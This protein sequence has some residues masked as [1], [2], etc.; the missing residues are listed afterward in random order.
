MRGV[1]I[2][3][4][5]MVTK[6]LVESWTQ[7]F[8]FDIF[9][10]SLNNQKW[11]RK[12]FPWYVVRYLLSN[13]KN[14]GFSGQFLIHDVEVF[15]ITKILIPALTLSFPAFGIHGVLHETH[16]LWGWCQ[17]LRMRAKLLGSRIFY[18]NPSRALIQNLKY[19]SLG[20]AL[21]TVDLG[22]ARW[23]CSFL[24]FAAGS[25]Y[26]LGLLASNVVH[27]AV[28]VERCLNRTHR[29]HILASGV[30]VL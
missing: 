6:K 19:F 20:G 22:V 24:A 9:L 21:A 18:D 11:V 26:L 17:R 7:K 10:I 2:L 4:N 23:A 28:S 15:I 27:V 8:Y 14:H 29:W 5:E 12:R 16:T 30:D 25:N 1:V 13:V 3:I